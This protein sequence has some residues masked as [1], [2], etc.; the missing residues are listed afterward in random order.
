MVGGKRGGGAPALRRHQDRKSLRP[1]GAAALAI[2]KGID[3]QD[4]SKFVFPADRGEG[5]FQGTRG[6]WAKAIKKA[7]LPGVTA[8]YTKTYHV[9]HSGLDG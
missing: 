4:G 2:L 3:R 8:S 6:V 7:N 5:H 1:F 9:C